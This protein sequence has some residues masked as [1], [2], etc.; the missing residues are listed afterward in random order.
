[1][2]KI[3]KLLKARCLHLK[4]THTLGVDFEYL[5]HSES[6]VTFFFVDEGIEDPNIT[7]NGPS[8]ARQRNAI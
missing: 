1:M 4:K 3:R 7:I 8:S 5:R 6:M 2:R